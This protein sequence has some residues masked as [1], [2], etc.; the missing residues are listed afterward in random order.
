MHGEQSY[1]ITYTQ[2]NVTRHFADTGAD[3]FYW[4]INGTDWEQPFGRVTAAVTIAPDLLPRLTGEADAAV[5]TEGEANPAETT[6]TETTRTDDG[7]TFTATDLAPRDNLS[8][9][10]GFEPET[11][12]PRDDS[13]G[14]APWLLF[15]LLAT[16]AALATTVAAFVLR[17]TRLRAAPGR[18]IIA[19]EYA[20]LK[21][22]SV[23]LSAVI[24][25]KTASS[26]TAQI[27]TLAVAGNLRIL[28]VIEE[29]Q[30]PIGVHTDDGADAPGVEFLHALFGA[31]LSPG[32]SRNLKR[33]DHKAAKRIADLQS[34]VT[35]H[36]TTDGYRR[37]LPGGP[38]VILV[39]VAVLCTAASVVFA[40]ISLTGA[41]G[42]A[43]PDVFLAV[44]VLALVA[45]GML[46]ARVPLELKGVELR[47]HLLPYAV[48]F[49]LEKKWAEELG[50]YYEEVGTQPSWYAG[51]GAFNAALFASGIGSVSTS[52]S[53][54]SSTGGGSSGGVSSGGG[55]GGGV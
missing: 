48:L 24:L 15:S 55:G 2:H 8:F 6:R 34:R 54:Y 21:G 31:E 40:V 53:S 7:D 1:V 46:L 36:A 17:R 3:E 29:T 33:A 32:E 42:G 16:L 39:T 27:L 25:G 20:S 11:F 19:P 4:G 35:K 12:V 9:A 14:A 28:E 37:A 51:H 30:L 52:V 47:E 45:T 22:V 41:Y 18:G 38:M 26:N 43:L 44:G 49:G 10:I 13:F 50:R 23:L 5:G